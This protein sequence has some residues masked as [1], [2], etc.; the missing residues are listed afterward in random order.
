VVDADDCLQGPCRA[1]SI[2][3]KI[4][5]AWIVIGNNDEAEGNDSS[6][7]LFVIKGEPFGNSLGIL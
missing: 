4:G 1:L 7:G 2:A 5:F 3:L 6:R